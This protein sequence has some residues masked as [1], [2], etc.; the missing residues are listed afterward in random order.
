MRT[1]QPH[2]PPPPSQPS[3]PKLNLGSIIASLHPPRIF[4]PASSSSTTCQHARSRHTPLHVHAAV[5]LTRYGLRIPVR[6]SLA[7]A[8]QRSA[9]QRNVHWVRSRCKLPCIGSPPLIPWTFSF[10]LSLSFSLARID[11][12]HPPP[13]RKF[14]DCCMDSDV[15]GCLESYAVLPAANRFAGRTHG[16]GR[17]YGLGW[18]GKKKGT[19]VSPAESHYGIVGG[20]GLWSWVELFRS[21]MI[22][23][24][25]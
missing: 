11:L 23:R 17:D 14:C 10:L 7:E 19:D 6:C 20:V 2:T 22:I 12:L 13:V 21:A 16:T 25:A 24:T 9:A 5:P 18:R 15:E 4:V 8:V 1:L 3:K